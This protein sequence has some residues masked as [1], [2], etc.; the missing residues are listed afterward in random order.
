MINEI[1]LRRKNKIDITACDYVTNNSEKA[2][3]LSIAKNIESLGYTFSKE[4]YEVLFTFSKENIENFYKDLMPKLKR[5]TGA[6]KTYNPMYPNFPQQVM[7]ATDIELYVNAI[8][9]YF[10]FGEW[11]PQYAKDERLP[12]LD[13]N[14]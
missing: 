5:L 11:M 1:L 13:D 14:K 7:E 10:T 4:V 9:H 3:I 2:M 6:D 12:L 8:M